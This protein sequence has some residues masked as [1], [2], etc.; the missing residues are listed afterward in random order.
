MNGKIKTGELY[1]SKSRNEYL[2]VGDQFNVSSGKEFTNYK[3]FGPKDFDE[4]KFQI[5]KRHFNPSAKTKDVI[6]FL[7][8]HGFELVNLNKQKK[9]EYSISEGLFDIDEL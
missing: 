3:L 2:K 8:H 6:D 1:Y 4:Y 7:S 5:P 9:T